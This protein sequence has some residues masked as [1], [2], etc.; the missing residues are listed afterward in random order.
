M[1]LVRYNCRIVGEKRSI[2]Y[3]SCAGAETLNHGLA[4]V[5][6]PPEP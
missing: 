5:D 4:A 6:P 3:T 1:G 2:P